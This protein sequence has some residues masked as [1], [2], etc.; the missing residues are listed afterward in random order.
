MYLPR[1]QVKGFTLIELAIALLIF[2]IG[3]VGLLQLTVTGVSIDRL[4]AD[5]SVA[6][7][8]AQMKTDELSGNIWISNNLPAALTTGGDIPSIPYTNPLNSPNPTPTANYTDYFNATGTKIGS[9]AIA[10]TDTYFVRQWRILDCDETTCAST[11]ATP[12]CRTKR[13]DVVVT[14]LSRAFGRSYP[15]ATVMVYKSAIN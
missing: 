4:A 6:A 14:V 12:P 5:R 3:V 15:A 13:I 7:T 11:C 10:P 8:L 1:N 2:L 9:G